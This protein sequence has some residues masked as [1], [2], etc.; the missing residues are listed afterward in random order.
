M[1]YGDNQHDENLRDAWHTFCDRLKD[2]DQAIFRDPAPATD[3]ERATGFQY[4]SRLI[5][6]GLLGG[7]EHINPLHPQFFRIM[8]PERKWGGDNPDCLYLRA[9]I[10]GRHTYRIVGQRGGAAYIVFTV[11]KPLASVRAGHV[12][13]T[14]LLLGT[15]VDQLLGK[16]LD[17]AWDGSFELVLSPDH[18][19]GNWIETTPEADTILVRQFFGAW[20]LEE[21]MT[22]RIERVG[23]DDKPD[24]ITPERLAHGLREAAEVVPTTIDYWR[25]WHQRFRDQPNSFITSAT[26]SKH[27]AAPGGVLLHCGWFVP[28]DEAM[29][30]RLELPDSFDYWEMEMNNFWMASP[31][32]RY[33]LVSTNSHHAVPEPDGSVLVILSHVDPGVPN[34]IDASGHAEGHLTLRWMQA[35]SAPVPNVEVVKFDDLETKLPG[36]AQRIDKLGRREQLRLRRIGVD[37]R[38]RV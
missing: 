7:L 25:D 4:A 1:A 37:K 33:R 29:I 10:D 30:V 17:V 26:Q 8:S 9:A 27:G 32:Y 15:A 34:W 36:G 3:F 24:Q 38:F 18:H 2:V 11:Q 20:H 5:A 14:D 22:V 6:A 19:E 31:D 35:S 16:D 28:S 23:A 21:P 13:G 12:R